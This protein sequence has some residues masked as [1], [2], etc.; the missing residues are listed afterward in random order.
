LQQ[1]R[2]LQPGDVALSD[3]DYALRHVVD[4]GQSPELDEL[5]ELF[6]A[7]GSTQP[8]V[9]HDDDQKIRLLE[10]VVDL[11]IELVAVADALSVEPDP[12]PGSAKIP[13]LCS[14]HFTEKSDETFFVLRS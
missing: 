4:P 7:I 14:Q 10:A 11:A 13:Q 5:I 12:G 3:H 8:V 6:S 9:R 1:Q 2:A